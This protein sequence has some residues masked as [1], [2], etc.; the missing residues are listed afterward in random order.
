MRFKQA[1]DVIYHAE[2]FHLEICDR[3]RQLSEESDKARLKLLLDYLSDREK[4]LADAL[5][6]FTEEISQN[7]L[8]TWFQFSGDA[9][10]LSWPDCSLPP[11]IS[12]DSV[13]NL[14]IRLADCFIRLYGTIVD[15]AD[16]DDVRRVFRNLLEAEEHEKTVLVR[17]VQL[18]EDL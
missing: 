5:G 9:D 13:V 2:Q 17:N 15:Q 16:S 6:E 12:T 18:L 1:R 8:D 3:Y 7:I 11:E 10:R 14:S 4:M